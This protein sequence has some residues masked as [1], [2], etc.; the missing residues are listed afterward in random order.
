[1]EESMQIYIDGEL[2]FTIY[3]RRIQ[4]VP[5]EEKDKRIEVKV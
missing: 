1:M 3:G 5:N 2:W 4:I